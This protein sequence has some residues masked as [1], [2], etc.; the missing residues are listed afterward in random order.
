MLALGQCALG[1]DNR[2]R[3]PSKGVLVDRRLAPNAPPPPSGMQ[4]EPAS[5]APASTVTASALGRIFWS[6]SPYQESASWENLSARYQGTARQHTLLSPII[7]GPLCVGLFQEYRMVWYLGKGV[8]FIFRE[9][10]GI[11]YGTVLSG[12]GY[13]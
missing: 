3:Q 4:R 5:T 8:F 10:S 13:F 1:W 12:R 2:G 7:I 6:G 11:P 9:Y